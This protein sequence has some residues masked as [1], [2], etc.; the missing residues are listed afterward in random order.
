MSQVKFFDSGNMSQWPKPKASKIRLTKYEVS[1]PSQI[2]QNSTRLQNVILEIN[3]MS[4]AEIAF[5]LYTINGLL[6][7]K[8]YSFGWF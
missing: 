3:Q 8:S 2:D 7:S 6:H 5:V 4:G 1:D